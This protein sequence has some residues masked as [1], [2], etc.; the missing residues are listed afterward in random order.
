MRFFGEVLA[1]EIVIRDNE[2]MDMSDRAQV[3]R[4]DFYTDAELRAKPWLARQQQAGSPVRSDPN[5]RPAS[6]E[7]RALAAQ[8]GVC[9]YCLEPGDERSAL[10][11]ETGRHPECDEAWQAERAERGAGA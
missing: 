4:G 5:N 3:A 10:A 9:G 7:A 11:E 6:A 2:V 1:V 8:P